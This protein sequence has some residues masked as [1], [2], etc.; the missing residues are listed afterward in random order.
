MHFRHR[1]KGQ[2]H[3][4]KIGFFII[5]ICS[6]LPL[7]IF[8]LYSR[9]YH[10]IHK[11]PSV[12]DGVLDLEGYDFSKSGPIHLDGSWE[13]YWNQWIITD[14]ERNPADAFLVK[15][16]HSWNQIQLD[17]DHLPGKG[18]ASYRL[19][20]KNCPP[21]ESL[22]SYIPNLG[23]AYRVFFNGEL[24]AVSGN[25]TKDPAFT[26]VSLSLMLDRLSKPLPPQSEVVIEMS[27]CHSGGLYQTPILSDSQSDYIYSSLR[28][29]TAAMYVGLLVLIL[30]CYIYTMTVHQ[31]KPQSLAL[32]FLELV[33]FLR[34]LVKD[35]F[36][37][38]IKLFAPF[39]QYHIVNN[40]LL[41]LSLF[42]P[43]AFI[44]WAKD[45]LDTQ[46]NMKTIRL[47]IGFEL[48]CG[49]FILYYSIAGQL[50]LVFI[51]F[52]ISLI[53]FIYLLYKLYENLVNGVPYALSVASATMLILSSLIAAGLYASGLVIINIS[54][55][56]PTAFLLAALIHVSIYLRKNQ[57]LHLQALENAQL[58]LE[59]KE[60]DTTLMLSQIKPHFL[61]N[62]L[63][64]IQVLCMHDPVVASEAIGKFSNYLR[65]NMRSINSRK[66]IPLSQEL[67][68]V[69]NYAAIELLRFKDR[70]HIVYD[71]KV[72][73]FK[74]PPLT[75]QPIVEN[76][77][78]HG[79]CKKITGGTVTLC[80]YEEE[81]V[82][83]IEVKDNGVGFD[84]STLDQKEDSYGLK[85]ISFRLKK[86]MNADLRI[87]SAP[88]QGTL[89]QIRI[90]KGEYGFECDHN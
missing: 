49:I 79:V 15:I 67:E 76:A 9:Y 33:I 70:L 2:L 48:F 30:A 63:V 84:P 62:A 72:R 3:R 31:V 1:D 26:N 74:V 10:Q 34:I 16:P 4:F 14:R 43:S 64:A 59:L 5:L 66:P 39:F 40:I 18:Y 11:T 52:V 7:I 82:F 21:D 27:A 25:P 23:G 36:F 86:G 81:L 41:V 75:I 85:N 32:L 73:D 28:H 61:Y 90:P 13:F 89:V 42:L 80:T 44:L 53:P 78:K 46:I 68:H 87:E 17:G 51:L 24:A 22:I 29:N 6:L 71:L 69:E 50:M 8:P 35:E 19:L 57:T 54:L 60:K 58:K 12:T 37:G 20:L 45:F 77:I 65:V 83:V 47:T 38:M 55:Y 88:D 56:P